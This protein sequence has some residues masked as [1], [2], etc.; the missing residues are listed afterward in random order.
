MHNSFWFAVFLY[1]FKHQEFLSMD[2]IL[3][4]LRIEMFDA[5]LTG[6]LK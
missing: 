5:A 6:K 1:D 3:V 4:Y 2:L